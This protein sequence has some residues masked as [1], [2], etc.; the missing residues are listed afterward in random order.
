MVQDKGS[1]SL[2]HSDYY[3]VFP[4]RFIEETAPFP[5]CIIGFLFKY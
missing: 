1:G 4:A 3:S 2:I 5:W